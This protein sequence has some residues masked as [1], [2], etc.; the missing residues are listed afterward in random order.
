MLSHQP[1]TGD[2]ILKKTILSASVFNVLKIRLHTVKSFI[3]LPFGRG[4]RASVHDTSL[5]LQQAFF[6]FY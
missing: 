2:F 5:C 4:E 1:A 6:L 3:L